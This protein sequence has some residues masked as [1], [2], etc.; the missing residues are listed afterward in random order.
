MDAYPK[1]LN[2]PE[3]SSTN[4]IKQGETVYIALPNVVW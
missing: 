2:A 3:G 1:Q 4:V